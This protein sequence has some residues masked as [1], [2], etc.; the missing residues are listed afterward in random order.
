MLAPLQG[1]PVRGENASFLGN[2]PGAPRRDGSRDLGE[3]RRSASSE[4]SGFALG[5]STPLLPRSPSARLG[6]LRRNPFVIRKP[7]LSS[8]TAARCYAATDR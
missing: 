7:Y 8:V 2:R 5:N 4:V 6:P 1:G 3:E